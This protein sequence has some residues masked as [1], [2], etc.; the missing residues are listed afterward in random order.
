MSVDGSKRLNGFDE[1]IEELIALLR[2]HEVG[3][4]EVKEFLDR[5]QG[6]DYVG[7]IQSVLDVKELLDL[8]LIV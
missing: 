3:S 8:G 2:K 4:E 5:H 6:K 1:P 7:E